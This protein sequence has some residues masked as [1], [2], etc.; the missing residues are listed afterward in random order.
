MYNDGTLEYEMKEKRLKEAEELARN[1]DG[2]THMRVRNLEYLMIIKLYS[3][4]ESW[5]VLEEFY[6]L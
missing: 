5:E 2:H 1:N 4:N 3:G 6:T